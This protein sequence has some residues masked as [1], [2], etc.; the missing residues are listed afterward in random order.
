MSLSLWP[1]NNVIEEV[2]DDKFPDTLFVANSFAAYEYVL[3]KK[4]ISKPKQ[5]Y[6]GGMSNKP[7]SFNTSSIS[8]TTASS[9]SQSTQPSAFTLKNKGKKLRKFAETSSSVCFILN[10]RKRREIL[11]IFKGKTSLFNTKI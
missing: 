3:Q 1:S 2:L 6:S 8:E 10:R 4:E 5:S 11:G 9:P 7:P